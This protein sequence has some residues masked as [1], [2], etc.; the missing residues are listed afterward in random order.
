MICSDYK[1]TRIDVE[2]GSQEWLRLRRSHVC[3]SDSLI[4]ME[5]SPWRTR[6]ELLEEK[7][8]EREP[9]QVNWA[10]QRGTLL[11]PKA[12]SFAENLFDTLFIPEV[13]VSEEYPF[14]LASYDGISFDGKIILEIKCPGKK[15][16]SEAMHGKIPS[17]YK[18]QLQHQMAV[19]GSDCVHYLSYYEE[20]GKIEGIL[21]IEKRDEE[22][23]KNMIEMEYEFYD[24]M[25][26]F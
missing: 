6:K 22:F 21:I 23:I 13:H 8:G 10:M 20:K 18:P 14:M 2:Q 19:R 24:E 7:R 15:A 3:A 16:H 9:Q 12:R 5:L 1:S 4:V 26:R 25:T 11:E 17:Y